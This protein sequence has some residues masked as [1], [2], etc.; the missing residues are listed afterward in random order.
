MSTLIDWIYPDKKYCLFLGAGFSKWATKLPLASELFDYNI[1]NWGV[2]ETK[3]LNELKKIKD[4]WDLASPNGN[5][6]EFIRVMIES[7]EKNKKIVTWYIARRLADPFI[8]E[9]HPSSYDGKVIQQRRVM[10]F[11]DSRRLKNKG[12]VKARN[13]IDSMNNVLLQGII[14]TN[15]DLL[16]E[17]CLGTKKFNYGRKMEVLHGPW[18]VP[19][20][21]WRDG[22]VV[23]KGTLPL[24]KLH[25]SISKTEKG[26]CCD[27][28]GGINGRALIIPPTHNKE[29]LDFVSHE[30]RVARDILRKT[31]VIIFFGFAFNQYDERILEL[32]RETEGWIKRIILIN[33]NPQV[34]NYARSIWPNADIVF[35]HPD[36][37][38]NKLIKTLDLSID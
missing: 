5:P 37:M 22:P 20:R 4:D 11:D 25:G 6:E 14:T 33:R 21:G 1:K 13:F 16:V 17:Y 30:W 26:Y 34:V 36:E 9:G 28:R 7:S 12:I 10:M 32:L 23:L 18:A 27:G 19:I 2:R 15:Y 8:V 29:I 3:K 38:N 31:S 24:I 35:I